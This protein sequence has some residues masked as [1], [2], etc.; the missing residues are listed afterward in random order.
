MTFLKSLRNLW[1]SRWPWKN[2]HCASPTEPGVN[3]RVWSGVRSFFRLS[4]P[5]SLSFSPSLRFAVSLSSSSSSSTLGPVNDAP[6]ALSC[7]DDRWATATYYL[8][9]ST[10][11]SSPRPSLFCHWSLEC[12]ENPRPGLIHH[13][14][15]GSWICTFCYVVCV[16]KNF[17]CIGADKNNVR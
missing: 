8:A 10:L 7:P 11:C 12:S 3:R 1:R 15:N 4:S 16:F 14:S 5:L 2:G 17:G 13:S 6:A 9:M